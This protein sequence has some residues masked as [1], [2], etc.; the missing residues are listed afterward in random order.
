MTPSVSIAKMLRAL[1]L[2]GL[3]ANRIPDGPFSRL[4]RRAMEGRMRYVRYDRSDCP[5]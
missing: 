1:Q 5:L 3:H 4:L 2:V